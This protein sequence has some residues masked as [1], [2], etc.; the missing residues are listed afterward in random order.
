MSMYLLTGFLGIVSIVAPY[1]FGYSLDTTALWTS[2]IIGAVLLIASIFEGVAA[3]KE[4]WEYW[5]LG[6][7]G[8]VA[9]LAPFIFGFATLAAAFWTLLIIGVVTIVAAGAK[10]FSGQTE[11]R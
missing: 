8:V 4:K 2:I 10:L 9:V 7:T 3:G 5:V 1:L 11:Y 6:I